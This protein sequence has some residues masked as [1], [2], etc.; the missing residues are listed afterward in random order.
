MLKDRWQVGLITA[1]WDPIDL[2]IRH[3]MTD[4]DLLA[5]LGLDDRRCCSAGDLAEDPESRCSELYQFIA[6][7][8]VFIKEK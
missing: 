8:A 5:D 1:N 3:S 6:A 4:Q 7:L 2:P